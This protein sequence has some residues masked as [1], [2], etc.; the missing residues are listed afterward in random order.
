MG[1]SEKKAFEQ[2]LVRSEGVNQANILERAFQEK[3]SQF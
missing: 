2:K 1:L 3:E